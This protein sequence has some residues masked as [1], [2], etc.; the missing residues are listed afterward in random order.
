MAE[1]PARLTVPCPVFSNLGLDLARPFVVKRERCG[2]ATR[3]NPG[4]MKVWAVILLCLNTHAVKILMVR[5]YSTEDFLLMWDGFVADHGQPATVHTDRG[6]QL[7]SAAKRTAES[8]GVEYD[9]DVI[10]NS[11]QGKTVWYFAPP[12][13]QHRN[14]APEAFVKKFKRSLSLLTGDKKLSMRHT[15][16]TQAASIH[17]NV[18]SGL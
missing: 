4:T 10:S 2:V 5:G 12:G 14:G 16:T 6:S 7:V 1:L 18:P 17:S 11:M 8:E 3:G 15:A 13:G 9:W